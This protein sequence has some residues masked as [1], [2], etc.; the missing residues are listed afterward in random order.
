MIE[1]DGLVKEFSGLRAVDGISLTII[2]LTEQ[3]FSIAVI[4]F[5]LAH[6][7]LQFKK[8]GM[9]VNIE[10]DI[11]GKY[12]QKFVGSTHSSGVNEG[13]LKKHGFLG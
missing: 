6:T 12:V 8:A 7:A 11:L 9:S 13:M 4:P 5:T 3:T 1:V 2:R 10:C